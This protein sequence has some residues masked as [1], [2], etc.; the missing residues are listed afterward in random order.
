MRVHTEQSIVVPGPIEAVFDHA[1]EGATLAKLLTGW[2][3]VP[4]TTSIEL[5]D[6]ATTTAVGVKRRVHTSDGAALEEEVLAFDRPH[7]HTYRLYGN[8]RGPAKLLVREGQGD[9]T[10][11][12][13]GPNSTRVVWRYH[14][15]LRS[16]LLWPAGFAMIRVAFA[17]MMRAGLRNLAAAFGA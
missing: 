2:G 3:P 15:E 9:W 12:S 1:C 8:F 7:R 11:A 4:A 5:L 6:G 16:P 17:G 14:F 13:L 10:F